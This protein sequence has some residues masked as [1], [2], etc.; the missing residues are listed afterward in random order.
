MADNINK[1]Q[2]IASSPEPVSY[3]GTKKILDQMDNSVCRIFNGKKGTGFFTKIPYNNKLLPVLITNNH[4]IGQNDIKNN[5]SI[6]LYIHNYKDQNTKTIKLDNN[7]LRYT[8]EKLD[9][10][11]IEIKENSDNL[12]NKYLVLDEKIKKYCESN[13][14]D[15]SSLKNIYSSN[16]IYIL[17]YRE[18]KNIVVSYGKSPALS[19][20]SEIY[21]YCCT[22]EG[23]SGSPILLINNQ[24]LI[25][26]HCGYDKHYNYNCGKLLSSSIKE[27]QK[28][29]NNLLIIN[30]QGIEEKNEIK[31]IKEKN[32]I[33]EIKDKNEIKEI[34]DKNEIK[35]IKEKNKI[36]K[37]KEIYEIKE[38]KENNYIQAEFKIEQ[39]LNKV[40]VINS[41]EEWYKD[42]SQWPQKT[43]CENEKDIKDNC[44]I[45]NIFICGCGS[46]YVVRHLEI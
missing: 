40:K 29:K 19:T 27:F 37:I 28:I 13:K 30:K 5:E 8:N 12:N 26:I 31:E 9:V 17:N 18:D 20:D 38:I 14:K 42:H 22:K 2:D 21:H 16:S 39:E 41:Y 11:I 10:T 1:E 46:N 32:E 24:K 4:I 35:E 36:K 45:R 23:S 43:E 34:K 7:R 3:E 15:D 25:G 33:K 44:E 6:T